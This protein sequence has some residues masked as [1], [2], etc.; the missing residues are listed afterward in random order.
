MKI[1]ITNENF[2]KTFLKKMEVTVE[3]FHSSIFYENPM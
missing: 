1:V 3:S 2:S